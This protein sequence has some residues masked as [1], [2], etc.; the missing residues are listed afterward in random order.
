MDEVLKLALE[1]E[2]E[3]T[4]LTGMLTAAEIVARSREEKVTH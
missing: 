3:M 1:R 4:A 2:I